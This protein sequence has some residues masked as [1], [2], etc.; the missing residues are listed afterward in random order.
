MVRVYENSEKS[1]ELD[2]FAA[3][4]IELMDFQTLTQKVEAGE[5]LSAEEQKEFVAQVA[6]SL[7]ELAKNEP[8]TYKKTLEEITAI[9]S[10]LDANIQN[11]LNE[12]E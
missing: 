12:K 7:E 3:T 9:V 1:S 11:V 4:N 5:Q 6:T 8:D 2:R 10:S